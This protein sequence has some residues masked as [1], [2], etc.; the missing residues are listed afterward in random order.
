MLSQ[1]FVF[2]EPP[3]TA[4][5]IATQAIKARDS[6][7]LENYRNDPLLG[8]YFHI[9]GIISVE[10]R[11][12]SECVLLALHHLLTPKVTHKQKCQS[13]L[14]LHHVCRVRQ[15]FESWHFLC[16]CPRCSDPTEAGANTNTMV[17]QGYVV[18][19]Y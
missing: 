19:K 14:L 15:L 17:K 5:L 7:K 11:G 18:S 9:V 13:V 8:I 6:L 12:A 16:G 2:R 1:A 4:S 10:G 3:F